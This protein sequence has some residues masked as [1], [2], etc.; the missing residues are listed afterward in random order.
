M[1]KRKNIHAQKLGRLGGRAKSP[2]KTA[3]NLA[4]GLQHN[5]PPTYCQCSHMISR[6]RWNGARKCKDCECLALQVVD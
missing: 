3:A 5:R 1:S 2:A 6:H 4:K